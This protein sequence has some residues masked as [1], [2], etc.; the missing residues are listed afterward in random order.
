VAPLRR[1]GGA[2]QRASSRLRSVAAPTTRFAAFNSLP[3]ATRP[4]TLRGPQAPFAG[5]SGHYQSVME[6]P[7]PNLRCSPA[8][9]LG[10]VVSKAFFFHTPP[11]WAAPRGGC[12]SR[13]RTP[14][15]GTPFN[16][17]RSRGG[18]KGTPIARP[19]SMGRPPR[20]A[21]RG[22]PYPKSR[23]LPRGRVRIARAFGRVKPLQNNG[24]RR[25]FL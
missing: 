12:A 3:G 11:P 2:R 5:P 10:V 6:A 8:Q 22:F 20:G 17:Y 7:P 4:Q 24:L 23:F 15:N 18:T 1:L 9:G 21:G 16:L 14:P 13:S 19:T 25:V